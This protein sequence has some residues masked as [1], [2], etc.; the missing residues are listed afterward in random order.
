VIS[1]TMVL[2]VKETHWTRVTEVT[3]GELMEDSQV[4]REYALS[5]FVQAQEVDLL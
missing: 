1:A 5:T 2:N 4:G 3:E